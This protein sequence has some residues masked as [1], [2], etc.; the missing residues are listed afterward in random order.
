MRG[1]I[2]TCALTVFLSLAAA[3]E[4]PVLAWQGDAVKPEHAAKSKPE[5]GA[6]EKGGKSANIVPLNKE[7]TV[8]LDKAGKKVLLKTKIV[9]REGTLEMFCCLKQTKEHESI[10]SLPA[11]A[12]P[13]H[14]G[15][16]SLGA[17][18][19]KPV[20]FVPEYKPP[21]GQRIDIFAQWTDE[22]GKLQRFPGQYFVR[23]VSH[24]YFAE[25]L[26]RLPPEV[27]LPKD[28]D[29]RYDDEEKELFFFGPMTAKQKEGY[30]ALSK[31]NA[32]QKAI[33][34][35]SKRGETRPMTAH[36]IFTGSG[37]DE[38]D[39]QRA[40]RAEMGDLICVANFASATLDVSVES[41]QGNDDLL[42]E[43]YTEHIPPI[44]TEVTLELIPVFE[45]AP[46]PAE[47]QSPDAGKK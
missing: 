34:S 20:Q 7:G 4:R 23:H 31:D 40:Y 10:F 46:K 16:L 26:Q 8:L 2:A 27:T 5:P 37:F 43:A 28:S 30:L 38:I 19:G 1:V 9:L 41:G 33:E 12:Y 18:P 45:K 14:A 35:L 21:T 15:L 22:K 29:L 42:F 39:G 13:V 6:S 47:K 24:R 17:E 25:K 36:W 32:Y 3:I 11:K 44:G